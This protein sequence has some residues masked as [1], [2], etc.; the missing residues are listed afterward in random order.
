MAQVTDLP[1]EL[2]DYVFKS[3]K[4]L[5]ILNVAETCKTLHAA[6][7]PAIYHTIVMRWEIRRDMG[8]GT[9]RKDLSDSSKAHDEE[10]IH[11]DNL[12]GPNIQLLLRTL[13]ETPNYVKLVKKLDFRAAHCTFYDD[14]GSIRRCFPNS[15][16]ELTGQELRNDMFKRYVRAEKYPP[17]HRW[18]EK[19]KLLIIMAMLIVTCHKHLESLSISADFLLNNEW[20][21]IMLRHGFAMN[22]TALSPEWFIKLKSMRVILEH[23]DRESGYLYNRPPMPWSIEFRKIQKTLLL[24]HYLPAVETLELSAFADRRLGHNIALWRKKRKQ[25]QKPFWPLD[26]KPR[27]LCLTT[28]RLK[29]SSLALHTLQKLLEH[30]PLV[31]VLE[32]EFYMHHKHAPLRLVE[33]SR[34]LRCIRRTLQ[35]LKIRAIFFK[36]MFPNHSP[37]VEVSRILNSMGSLLRGFPALTTLE[38]PLSVLIGADYITTGPRPRIGDLLPPSLTHLTLNYDLNIPSFAIQNVMPYFH[39]YLAGEELL[40]KTSTEVEQEVEDAII[41]ELDRVDLETCES[42]PMPFGPDDDEEEEEE[43]DDDDGSAG[44]ASS[45]IADWELDG[46]PESEPSDFYDYYFTS[47]GSDGSDEG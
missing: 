17:P 36:D 37:H 1:Q 10:A 29:Q 18:L 45:T 26:N 16:I 38:I 34:A 11:R 6:A 42:S 4:P 43:E 23:W 28:L 32:L 39:T 2:L 14:D 22:A 13:A 15:S 40:R 33:L 9:E 31:N 27:A 44:Y 12:P 20:F 3:L 47:S 41:Q 24:L 25:S 5:D 7:L 46:R 35:H 19:N 8:L 30:A 21:P